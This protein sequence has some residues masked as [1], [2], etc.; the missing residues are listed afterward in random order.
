[1]KNHKLLFYNIAIILFLLF[2]S[3]IIAFTI[4]AT[5]CGDGNKGLFDILN[6]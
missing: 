2:L 5:I 1:M 6:L 3:T 4:I